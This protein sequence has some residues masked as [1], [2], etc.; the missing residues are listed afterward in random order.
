MF[1]MLMSNVNKPASIHTGESFFC[2]VTAKRHR[3]LWRAA[4]DSERKNPI[5]HRRLDLISTQQPTPKRA[6]C[7]MRS[8]VVSRTCLLKCGKMNVTY[9]RPK[10]LEWKRTTLFLFKKNCVLH[11][12][13]RR[14][15]ARAPLWRSQGFFICI[16]ESNREVSVCRSLI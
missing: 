16:K 9:I 1:A 8:T 5:L 10:L 11:I 4:R 13:L 7:L 14:N 15:T 2:S 12:S 3:R 6:Q